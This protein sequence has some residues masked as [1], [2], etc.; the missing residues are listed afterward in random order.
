MT[1]IRLAALHPADIDAVV[2]LHQAAFPSFFLSQ[3]GTPF[4]RNFYAGFLTDPTS[5]TTVARANGRVVGAVVGTTAPGGFFRRLLGR[6][7]LGFALASA[8][9]VLRDPRRTLRLLRAV[10]YR[11]E[12]GER[13]SGALLSSIC[14]D[15]LS[16]GRGIGRRLLTEWCTTA[17]DLGATRA[18]LT[19]DAVDNSA[20]NAFYERSGW[21]LT[22]SFETPEH[23]AMNRYEKEL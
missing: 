20:V 23:R 14:V 10:T 8:Q 9:A 1:E 2:A 17:R 3:L 22:A 21:T 13:V 15:P 5:V 18:Y 16:E 6:R 7:L 19:T 11:G 12:A 4:L